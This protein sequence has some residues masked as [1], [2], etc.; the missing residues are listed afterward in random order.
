[1]AN[2]IKDES[3]LHEN[4]HPFGGYIIGDDLRTIDAQLD[5]IGAKPNYESVNEGLPSLTNKVRNAWN[6]VFH[7]DAYELNHTALNDAIL[8]TDIGGCDVL[9]PISQ[10]SPDDDIVWPAMRTDGDGSGNSG[11]GRVYYETYYTNQRVLWMSF[12]VPKFKKLSQFYQ[13]AGDS[14]LADI[15]TRGDVSFAK[16]LGHIIGGGISLTI[17][18]VPA[19]ISGAWSVVTKATEIASATQVNKYYEMQSRMDLYYK[20]V[21]VILANMLASME[22]FRWSDDAKDANLKN[23]LTYPRALRKG[24]DPLWVLSSK[25]NRIQRRDRADELAKQGFSI[26]EM[27]DE[28][29]KSDSFAKWLE[30]AKMR[31]FMFIGTRIE[32]GMELSESASNTTGESD[33][34]GKLR[35]ISKSARATQFSMSNGNL[36]GGVIGGAANL[37]KGAVE[38]SVKTLGNALGV[39]DAVAS[40]AKG[41]GF[42][43]IP[44]LWQDSSFNRGSYSFDIQLR[45]KDGHPYTVYQYILVPLAFYLAGALPIGLGL[46]MYTSPFM[47]QAYSPGLFSTSSGMI[48]ELSIKRGLPEFGWTPD[49]LPLAVDL[50]ITITDMS[51]MLYVNLADGKLKHLL[52]GND[53]MKTYLNTLCAVSVTDMID[54]YSRLGK[55]IETYAELFTQRFSGRRIAHSIFAD[56]FVSHASALFGR[57]KRTPGNSS[58]Y[59]TQ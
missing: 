12:G 16:K 47:C 13:D 50:S 58:G 41:S 35:G 8:D 14:R 10:F 45:A 23:A 43:D 1:M 49:N 54:G 33:I 2:T 7:P 48:T 52:D 27:Q 53:G 34:A 19:V 30:S 59:G 24:A 4:I 37:L 20:A 38:G 40:A 11:M 51:Q 44:H 3:V 46:N 32:R 15:M 56:G 31:E 36:G 21:S 28:L 55:R 18:F 26:P 42:F 5:A 29:E 22:L 39:G 9:N 17:S 25:R 6:E 57:N